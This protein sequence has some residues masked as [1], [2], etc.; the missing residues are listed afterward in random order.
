MLEDSIALGGLLVPGREDGGVQ[1]H[2]FDRVPN[3]RLPVRR[4]SGAEDGASG[5]EDVG[6]EDEQG[7]TFLLPQLL[8]IQGNGV[9]G[10]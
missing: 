10:H 9:E 8:F 2:A 1:S 4:Q 3:R 5:P 7:H 6:V